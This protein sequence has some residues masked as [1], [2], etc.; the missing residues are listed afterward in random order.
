MVACMMAAAALLLDAGV[1]PAP[2]LLGPAEILARLE[3]SKTKY[4]ITST[5]SAPDVPAARYAELLWPPMGADLDF[6]AVVAGTDGRTKVVAATLSP[7]ALQAIRAAE[8][9]FREGRYEAAAARYEEGLR[10]DPDSFLLLSHLG[11]CHYHRG[12]YGDALRLYE[13]AIA[14]LPTDHRLWF[15]KG[16]ALAHLGRG[17]EAVDAFVEALVL[18]PRYAL[19]LGWLE[20]NADALEI[21]VETAPVLAPKTFVRREGDRVRVFVDA[22]SPH[23]L[24]FGACK[25]LW[26][27]EP[28]RRLE[29]TGSA[30]PAFSSIEERE[31]IASLLT[32]YRSRRQAKDFVRDASLDRLEQIVEAGLVDGFILYELGSRVVPWCTIA[33]GDDAKE[34]VRRYVRRYVLVR[35]R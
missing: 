18:R 1:P 10:E 12:R 11:D 9:L 35:D 22:E 29:A 14:I 23:W 21:R 19:L 8:P 3:Q 20:R 31:C 13:R 24:A 17:A 16:Q 6:P 15:Y 26:L 28:S 32:V 34:M 5:E 4:E 27:G 30:S 2:R 7:G 33:A 25:A